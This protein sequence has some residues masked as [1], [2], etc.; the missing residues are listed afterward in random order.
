MQIYTPE[1]TP[2]YRYMRTT[3]VY[4]LGGEP[5]AHHSHE[6]LDEFIAAHSHTILYLLHDL[7]AMLDYLHDLIQAK[8]PLHNGAREVLAAA[9]RL[10]TEAQS[11]VPNSKA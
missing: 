3:I 8:E 5:K 6:A 11:Y 7:I 10:V 9:E 1:L 2:L 4:A